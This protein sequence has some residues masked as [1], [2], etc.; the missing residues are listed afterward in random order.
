MT[1]KTNFFHSYRGAAMH[2]QASPAAA[3]AEAADPV[4]EQPAEPTAPAPPSPR[5]PWQKFISSPR[6]PRRRSPGRA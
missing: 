3:P 6:W 2:G 5:K 4:D 1:R